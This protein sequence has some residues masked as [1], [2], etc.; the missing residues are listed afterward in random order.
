MKIYT[1][2]DLNE[3]ISELRASASRTSPE[4]LTHE[5]IDTMD[6]DVALHLAKVT[7]GGA[8]NICV[9]MAQLAR[10]GQEVTPDLDAMATVAEL[11][12]V[13]AK[14]W[15]EVHDR[16]QSIELRLAAETRYAEMQANR[17]DSN[18]FGV[19]VKPSEEDV[20]KTERPVT[21][22]LQEFDD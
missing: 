9:V 22:T 14:V 5:H 12:Q 1:T 10:P 20:A 3:L 8:D 18:P 16:M 7:A 11:L 2:D 13:Q 17:S 19:D 6:A 21:T 15:L 4:M